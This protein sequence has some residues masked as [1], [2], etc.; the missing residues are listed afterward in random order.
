MLDSSYKKY[1]SPNFASTIVI[2]SFIVLFAFSIRLFILLCY[3]EV[4][5][6]L[7]LVGF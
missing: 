7:Y 2:Y 5:V 6:S 3:L 4:Q 1:G